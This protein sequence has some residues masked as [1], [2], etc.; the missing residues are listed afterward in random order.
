M[1]VFDADAIPLDEN[2]C[3]LGPVGV[4]TAVETLVKCC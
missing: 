3:E 2:E 4:V 1:E